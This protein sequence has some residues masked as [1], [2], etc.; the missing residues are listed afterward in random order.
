MAC[1][2]SPA[3]RRETTGQVGAAAAAGTP[4]SVSPLK[5]S[6]GRPKRGIDPRLLF[7]L[8]LW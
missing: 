8:E 4:S 2:R 7:R 5:K 3:A 6:A 1:R